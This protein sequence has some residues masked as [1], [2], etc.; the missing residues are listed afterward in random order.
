MRL[1]PRVGDTLIT[2]TPLN[3]DS[4]LHRAGEYL[5]VELT[6][7]EQLPVAF[8]L[9]RSGGWKIEEPKGKVRDE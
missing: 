2:T 4:L 3:C 8:D 1:E 5:R 9:V 7:K 6:N